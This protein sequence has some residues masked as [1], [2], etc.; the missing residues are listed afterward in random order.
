MG[1]E[2][3]RKRGWEGG[4][5]G[6]RRKGWRRAGGRGGGKEKAERGNIFSITLNFLSTSL[7]RSAVIF[8]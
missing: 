8:R 2:R 1:G 4:R 5:E 7:P 6:G 3:K